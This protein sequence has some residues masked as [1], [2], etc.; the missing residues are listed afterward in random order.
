MIRCPDYFLTKPVRSACWVLAALLF[1]ALFTR[2]LLS[3]IALNEEADRSFLSAWIAIGR[4]IWNEPGKI[5]HVGYEDFGAAMISA[6]IGAFIGS[7]PMLFLAVGRKG[8]LLGPILV[9]TIPFAWISALFIQF[10][11][12]LVPD[13]LPPALIDTAPTLSLHLSYFANAD[14]ELVLG[15]VL[16]LF[17]YPFLFGGVVLYLVHWFAF[18]RKPRQAQS[19]PDARGS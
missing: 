19:E 14:L 17:G 3:Q 2:E 9:L 10:R 15:L 4:S 6:F 16:P 1:Y 8:Y 13:D 5:V 7:L 11:I 18:H 12:G